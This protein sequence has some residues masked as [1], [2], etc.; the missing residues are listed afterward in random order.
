MKSNKGRDSLLIVDGH[1]LIHRAYHAMPS[2][3][4]LPDGTPT[5]AIYGFTKLLLAALKLV[6]PTCVTVAFDSRGPTFRHVKFEA[7]KAHRERPDEDMLVQIPLVKEVVAALSI[8]KYEVPGF[9][10]DDL[11]GTVSRQAAEQGLD[12]RILTGDMDMLQLVNDLIQV[13]AP[14]KGMNEPTIYTPGKVV[15]KYGFGPEKVTLYKAL[16]GDPSDNIPGVAGIGDVTATRLTMAASNLDDLLDRLRTGSLPDGIS[17]KMAQ[18]VI[19]G[20]K[21]ARLSFELATIDQESPISFDK[22]SC[23]T[24]TFD[25]DL[26]VSTFVRLGFR[27]LLRDLPGYDPD[28]RGGLL[29]VEEPTVQTH[30]LNDEL[31]PVLRQLETRGVLIDCEYLSNLDKN[32]RTEMASLTQKIWA[33]AGREVNVDSPKQLSTLLFDELKLPTAGVKKGLTGLS[34]GARELKRLADKHPII[35]LIVEYREISK[36]AT[37]YT[38]PLPN[39]VGPDGRLHTTFATDT[40]TGRISSKNPNLQNIP[41]R[42]ERGQKIRRAFI[43]RPNHTLVRADYSQ[44]ELRV[45]AHL[46]REPHLIAAFRAGKDIHDTTAK[47]MNVDRRVAK[48]INFSLLYGKGAFGLSED[49]GCSREEAASF[50]TKYFAAYPGI[51]KWIAE[52][53]RFLG[54]HGYVETLFGWRRHFSGTK[55]T[56]PHRYSRFGR[57]A[58]NLPVQGTAAEILKRAMIKIE[59][60]EL[61]AGKMILTVHD[62]IV[63]EVPSGQAEMAGRQ[64]KKIME[65]TTTLDVPLIAE[66]GSG[67]N[68]G[69]TKGHEVKGNS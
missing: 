29:A 48:V 34:T 50:I 56:K 55:G 60:D 2:T 66:V 65:Q 23:H 18:K 35:P 9:E 4:T 27:S 61:L 31:A 42:S 57:E 30:P 12:V 38:T 45:V 49:I 36:L 28:D 26:A 14:K 67:T 69:D 6:K 11:I 16:K 17:P 59:A 44:I 51:E 63:V 54:T 53:L 64:L 22:Q 47:A 52:T 15:D 21:N 37:T 24:H 46:A 43:A 3:L 20:E 19:D 39:L 5:G 7:Y 68:W 40:S 33:T 1:A 41:I 25:R 58:I 62:E 8:P 13:V 32:W 10:A